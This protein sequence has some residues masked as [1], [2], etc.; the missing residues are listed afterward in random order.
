MLAAVRAPA[1][2]P[3]GTAWLG[4]A[5]LAAATGGTEDTTATVAT[6]PADPGLA[7]AAR[8]AADLESGRPP[9]RPQP[10]AARGWH[11]RAEA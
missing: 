7:L 3:A 5:D 9:A 1:T 4:R 6:G 11:V 2:P 10:W 8:V